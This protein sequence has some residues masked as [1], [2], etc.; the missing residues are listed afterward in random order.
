MKL[1]G[2]IFRRL[3]I[4]AKI[5]GGGGLPVRLGWKQAKVFLSCNFASLKARVHGVRFWKV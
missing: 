5:V 3:E 2:D 4:I 1:R